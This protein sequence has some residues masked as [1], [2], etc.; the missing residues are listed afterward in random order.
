MLDYF[1]EELRL[2][3]LEEAV[4]VIEATFRLFEAPDY[5]EE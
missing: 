4:Q 5:S 1:I 2:E 3:D